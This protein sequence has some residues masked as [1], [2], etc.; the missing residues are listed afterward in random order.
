MY[1]YEEN[2]FC[3]KRIRPGAIP[4]Y[5]PEGESVE[6]LLQRLEGNQWNG[7]I[8]GPHGTGKSTLLAAILPALQERKKVVHLELQD[9]VRAL[10]LLYEE[11]ELMDS[12]TVMA[13]D[14]YEQLSYWSRRRLRKRSRTQGFGIVVIAHVSYDYPLLYQTASELSTARMLVRRLLENT[15]VQIPDSM[16]EER[17]HQYHGNVREMLFSLYDDYEY[18]YRAILHEKKMDIP[19]KND[20]KKF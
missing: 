9:G 15:I 19:G 14:G 7:E 5:F 16:V 18:A 6:T 17:F 12:E 2:P 1:P 4:F 20:S 11:Y 8:I 3:S 10:P 13:I